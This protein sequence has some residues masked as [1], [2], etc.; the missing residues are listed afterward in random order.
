MDDSIRTG[1]GLITLA[2]KLRYKGEFQNNKPIIASNKLFVN[3]F[4]VK[5]NKAGETEM[6]EVK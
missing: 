1:F 4:A 2:D 6:L 5:T 3:L